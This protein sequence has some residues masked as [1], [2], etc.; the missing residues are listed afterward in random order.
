MENVLHHM[1]NM[2]KDYDDNIIFTTGVGNH[3]M[4]TYQFIKSHYPKKI[5]S[6]GSLGVM[7]A[8]LPYAIGAQTANPNKTV[9]CVDGDSS[10]NM[11]LTDLKTVVEKNLPIKIAIM[12]NNAQMMVTIWE[13]L[14]YE[15]RYAATLNE[16]NPSFTQ[17]SKSCGIKALK[18]DNRKDL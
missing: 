15:E 17:T 6:S 4:Q 3:Q 2:T 10:F 11:T 8:G 5:I 9:I 1:Y 18:C 13:K 12:N 16:R 7:C 14:F